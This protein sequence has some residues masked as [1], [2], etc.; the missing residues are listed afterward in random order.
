MIQSGSGDAELCTEAFGDPADPPVL[1]IMGA[2]TSLVWWEEAFCER[3]V[4]GGGT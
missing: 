2:G 3:L 1:L 4:P